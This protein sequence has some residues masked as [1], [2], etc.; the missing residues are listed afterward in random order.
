LRSRR[1]I[2]VYF[3]GCEVLDFA[4]PLQAFHEANSFGAK[5]CIEHSAT[6]P[7]ATT[8]Q[9]L[10]LGGLA[11]L[12]EVA[13]D[14]LVLVPGFTVQNVRLPRALIRWLKKSFDRGAVMT[15]VCTGA[16]ALAQAGLLENRRCT[17]HWKRT[18]ELQKLYPRADVLADRLFVEDG[19][20]I[21]SAGI[22]AGIDMA[23]ALIQSHHGPLL[24]AKV[25]REMVVY[26]RRDAHH[27]QE[28]VYLDYRTHLHPG[29]HSVQDWLTSHPAKKA[30]IAELAKMAHMSAR[31]LT[32][33][34]RE[35]TGVSIQKYRT[36]LRLEQARTLMNNPE[37]TLEAIA[38]ECGFADAR[39]FRR[40]WRKAY[41]VAPSQTRQESSAN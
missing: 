19:Q 40:V 28:S 37:L 32:R 7:H 14:D 26:I 38:G 20:V 31:N 4:G 41:Q 3:D 21:T 12:P 29:V 8:N 39:Q 9:G 24:A 23:L 11:P 30:R 1:V 34:F 10:K 36:R 18:A 27:Q 17:T 35:V 16:F 5:Y 15:S 22:A 2:F 25:A 13:T 6:A 33:A